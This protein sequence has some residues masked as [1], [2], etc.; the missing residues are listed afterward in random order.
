MAEFLDKIDKKVDSN[1]MADLERDLSE[2][3]LFE[4]LKS[5]GKDKTPGP[6]GLTRE[7]FIEFWEKIKIPYMR[8]V[9]EIKETE[10]LSEMQKRGAIKISHKKDERNRLKNY[11]PITLLNIDLKKYFH[12]LCCFSQKSRKVLF[13][14][15]QQREQDHCLRL[16]LLRHTHQRQ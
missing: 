1:D 5:L 13:V 8:C 9:K 14:F 10:E 6:D 15:S 12:F 7:W 2:R 4:A 3:E 11:R 16:G